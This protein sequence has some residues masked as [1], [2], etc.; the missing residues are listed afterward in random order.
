M[1]QNAKPPAAVIPRTKNRNVLLRTEPQAG[2]AGLGRLRNMAHALD[3]LRPKLPLTQSAFG[4]TED[5]VDGL[6]KRAGL[7]G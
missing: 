3:E 1:T 4:Y 6:L 5:R 2:R 7:V